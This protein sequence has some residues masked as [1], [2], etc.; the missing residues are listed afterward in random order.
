MYYIY[1]T[2]KKFSKAAA[3]RI[4]K[5]IKAIDPQAYFAGPMSI[6]GNRTTGWLERP[7]DGSNNS[8]FQATN[9]KA[10]VAIIE[11]ELGV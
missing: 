2:T 6:P 7:N 10:M 1:T 8:N 3:S 11:K 9:A 4:Q 5:Q